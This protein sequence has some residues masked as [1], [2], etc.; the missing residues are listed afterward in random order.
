MS[1]SPVVNRCIVK[2]WRAVRKEKSDEPASVW[3]LIN[4]VRVDLATLLQLYFFRKIKIMNR[5]FDFVLAV[6]I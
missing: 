5:D 6:F 4:Q 2:L 3:S 1:S